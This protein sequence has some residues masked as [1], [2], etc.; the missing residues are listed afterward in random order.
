MLTQLTWST[1]AEENLADKK[2]K[3]SK[4]ESRVGKKKKVTLVVLKPSDLGLRSS[5]SEPH[6]QKNTNQRDNFLPKVVS[7]LLIIV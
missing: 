2:P 3:A 5:I 1:F 6:K 4:K 7:L